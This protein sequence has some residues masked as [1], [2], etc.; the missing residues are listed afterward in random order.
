MARRF[1]EAMSLGRSGRATREPHPLILVVCEGKVTEPR[2]FEDFSALAKNPLLRVQAIGGY[3]APLQVVE[4]AIHEKQSLARQARRTRDSFD[5]KYEVWAAFDLDDQAATVS[6]ALALAEQNGV[7]VAFSNPCFEVWGLMHFSPY[8]RHSYHADAQRA[9]KEKLPGFCHETNPT[10]DAL[11]LQP[12]YPDA[13][14][15]AQQAAAERERD[16]VRFG[17][18]GNPS[19]TVYRLTE[20]ILQFGRK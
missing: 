15:Y 5:A 8:A 12:L 18:L 4:R 19:T 3:G 14:K 2:Y 20:R 13:V 1:R 17:R 10:L 11:A 7:N 16:G 9:L 6:D